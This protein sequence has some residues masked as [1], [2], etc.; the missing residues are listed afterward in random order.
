MQISHGL[1]LWI[2][3]SAKDKMCPPEYQE[4]RSEDVPKITK[5][6]VTAII[7][8]G[9]SLGT[10]SKIYTRTPTN[11]IHFIM[12]PNSR[13]EQRVPSEWAAFAYTVEGKVKFSAGNF[14][15]AHST[16][17]FNPGGDG[18]IAE[19]GDEPGNFVLISGKPIGEPVVQHGPFVMS[20]QKEI[21]EAI[22]DYSQAK[23][24][25]ENAQTWE[26][27]IAKKL[28][29]GWGTDEVEYEIHT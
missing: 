13:I 15:D 20:T 16:V 24:G 3:L 27:E 5:D 26:S 10:V 25:F 18:I 14:I 17:T 11:Y 9:E 28:N 29:Q 12:E 7:I 1:Q 19:T 4:L 21:I 22:N 6:G 23:N 2:N 8:A